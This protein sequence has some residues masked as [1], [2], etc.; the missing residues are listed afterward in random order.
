MGESGR[1]T[2]HGS[3]SS[4][5]FRPLCTFCF[6][7]LIIFHLFY[8]IATRTTE[9]ERGMSRGMKPGGASQWRSEEAPRARKMGPADRQVGRP[10]S[11]RTRWLE[12]FCLLFL[13]L[14]V[15]SSWCSRT[16]KTSFIHTAGQ[17]LIVET[18]S[19]QTAGCLEA[20]RGCFL[21]VVRASDRFLAAAA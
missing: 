8:L 4:V 13:V 18:P 5:P 11:P 17:L 19:C 21:S 6:S 16:L 10:L 1:A 14:S 9:W 7:F 15:S 3:C 2:K 12:G 20:R